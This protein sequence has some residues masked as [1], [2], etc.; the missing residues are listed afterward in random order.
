MEKKETKPLLTP[1]E[2]V[3]PS[4][5]DVLKDKVEETSK[6]TPKV[7]TPSEE[8]QKVSFEPPKEKGYAQTKRASIG[9]VIKQSK[10]KESLYTKETA[11]ERAARIEEEDRQRNAEAQQNVANLPYNKNG[12]GQLYN[13][14]DNRV[15]SAET[16]GQRVRNSSKNIAEDIQ[17]VVPRNSVYTWKDILTDPSFEGKRGSY[18]ID[19]LGGV[20][21]AGSTG[22]VANTGLNTINSV[23]NENFA[24]NIADR[25]TRAMNAQIDPLEAVNKEQTDLE[26]RLRDTA[27][28]AYIDRFNAAQDAETKRQTFEQMIND[29]DMWA[30]M[31][32]NQKLDAVMYL[33]AMAG[34]G[35]TLDLL[36]QE[37]LPDLLG[38]NG[39]KGGQVE[40]EPYKFTIN[41]VE[42]NAR[43]LYNQFKKSKAGE[44]KLYNILDSMKNPDGTPDLVT[45]RQFI[46]ELVNSGEW[47]RGKYL[48]DVQKHYNTYG[49]GVVKGNETYVPIFD[50]QVKTLGDTATSVLDA[51]NKISSDTGNS[52]TNKLS[53]I[54][55][56]I[57]AF[58]RNV[59][60]VYGDLDSAEL[61]D[62][63]SEKYEK[64][65]LKREQIKDA[66]TANVLDDSIASWLK[67][68]TVEDKLKNIVN[69]LG[70]QASTYATTHN[71]EHFR[72]T[73]GVMSLVS[74]LRSPD[75]R[76]DALDS[77][78]KKA[79][80][81]SAIKTVQTL[82]GYDDRE[83]QAKGLN[84]LK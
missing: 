40:T 73:N 61:P 36:L 72:D 4:F 84:K 59:T 38:G 25:D 7:E 10:P 33:R 58:E 5:K 12:T 56:R 32:L 17:N 46:D 24:K 76:S 16:T 34:Q 41:G 29:A 64:M 55:D 78:S 19:T 27:A 42:Y 3:T 18:I 82:C 51:I 48:N 80:Y 54:D 83:L 45:Q 37:Y 49:K 1:K 2:K 77:S 22:Q 52:Y 63:I 21:R 9:D 28:N 8:P 23:Q 53:A 35:S 60:E 44:E 65:K 67:K 20:L 15:P 30:G 68:G 70:S 39:N 26:L 66:Q 47:E 74:F 6:E 57:S 75:T 31:D 79:L 11:A 81:N 71:P 62:S 13:N 69:N 43:D 50:E 14:I